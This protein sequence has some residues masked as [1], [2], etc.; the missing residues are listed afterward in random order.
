MAVPTD[1]FTPLTTPAPDWSAAANWSSGA[2]PLAGDTAAITGTTALIDPG[3]TIET[4]LGLANG[5]SLIGNGGAIVFGISAD[6]AVSGNA[7]VYAADSIVNQGILALASGASLAVVVDLGALSGLT[8]AAPP[9]L[10][11]SGTIGL[12]TGATLAITGTEFENE[13]QISLVGG[14]LA[15]VGGALDNAAG[16]TGTID[17]SQ[18]ALASFGD[19]VADQSFTFGPGGGTLIFADPLLG[20]GLTLSGFSGTDTLVLPTLPGARL[21]QGGGFVTITTDAGIIDGSFAVTGAPDLSIVDQAGGSAIVLSAAQPIA[22]PPI[23]GAPGP[24]DPPCFT[25]GTA[26]LTPSGYR[27]VETLAAGDVIVTTTGAIHPIIWTGRHTADLAT[28]PNPAAIQPIRI[29]AGA[30]AP[31]VPR[32]TLRVS[33]DHAILLA[34]ALIPAKLLVNGATITQEHDTLAVTY[35]HLELDRHD[36]ILAEGAPCETYLDTGNRAGFSVATSWPVRPKRWDRD[37][38]APLVTSG[39]VLH[40]A[41]RA[42]HDIALAHGFTAASAPSVSLHID[43]RTI[44]LEPTGH[45]KLPPRHGGRAMIRSRRF[46]PAHFDPGSEDRRSLGI[47]LTAIRAARRR[48]TPDALAETGFH[49]RDPGDPACWTDGGGVIRIPQSARTLTIEI[50]ATPLEW[51]PNTR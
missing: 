8:G 1:D 20:P 49:P 43:G 14:T 13:G 5:A 2:V 21:T 25:R 29:A 50:A 7:A 23:L 28:H 22:A 12:A 36:T 42:L 31:G 45:Y 15:V 32:R 37:A 34:G 17:L 35:H 33:P 4:N 40:Q 46:I 39:P 27:P 44:P 10:A 3:V 30:L 38:C 24:T 11:N 26:I 18:G 16:T 6:L 41:R 19:G 48:F 51:M 47:A 9:S